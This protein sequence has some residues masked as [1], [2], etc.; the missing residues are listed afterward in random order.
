MF[1]CKK[2]DLIQIRESE[3]KRWLAPLAIP[4]DLGQDGA[5]TYVADYFELKYIYPDDIC[6]VLQTDIQYNAAVVFCREEKLYLNPVTGKIDQYFKRISDAHR[7][8]TTTD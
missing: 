5:F 2:G 6:L 8:S 1:F 3:R 7:A 4:L